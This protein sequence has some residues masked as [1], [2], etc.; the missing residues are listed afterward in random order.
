MQLWKLKQAEVYYFLNEKHKSARACFCTRQTDISTDWLFREQN[1]YADVFDFV[2]EEIK[3][4]GR[5]VEREG[6]LTSNNTK[7]VLVHVLMFL[8]YCASFRWHPKC[9]IFVW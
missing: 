6:G 3:E 8:S 5:R 4:G 2:E 1:T 9:R 7:V